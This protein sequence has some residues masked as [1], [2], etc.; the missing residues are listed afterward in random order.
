MRARTL[1]LALLMM[2]PAASVAR[3]HPIEFGVLTLVERADGAYDLDLHFSGGEEAPGSAAPWIDPGCELVDLLD[4]S[5]DFGLHLRGVL[6]CE[7]G[8]VG[9]RIG[10]RGLEG[11]SIEVPLTLTRRRGDAISALLTAGEPRLLVPEHP[12]RASVLRRYLA[13]GVEHI[14]IGIDHLL[15]VLGLYL[16]SRSLR[17]LLLTITAFT[18]GHSVTLA[19]A[20]LGLATLPGPPVE[21]CIALS[22]VLLAASLV[23]DDASRRASPPLLAVTFGLLHGFGFAGALAEIGLPRGELGLALF[24]FNLGVELGQLAFVAIVALASAIL[25]R[26]LA[27]TMRDRLR[28]LVP[29]AIGA[30]AVYFLLDRLGTLGG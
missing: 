13:L 7:G 5:L 16:A 26:L 14:A 12:D 27:E 23:R 1:V 19:L 6:R 2:G 28:L 4:V 18:L 29:Q 25:R 3:A 11:T 8:L 24:G 10:V 20:S 15:L 17:E 21:A 9:R 22:L 30:V